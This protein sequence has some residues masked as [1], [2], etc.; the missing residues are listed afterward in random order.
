MSLIITLLSAWLLALSGGPLSFDAADAAFERDA[1][2]AKSCS[3]LLE[4]LPKAETPAQN[5]RL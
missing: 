5:T 2:Y 1:D 4:M 3:L